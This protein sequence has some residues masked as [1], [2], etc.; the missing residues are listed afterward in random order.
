M[1]T[2][3]LKYRPSSVQGREGT[4]FY[5]IVHHRVVRSVYTGYHIFPEE[6]NASLSIVNVCGTH[7]RQA[8]LRLIRSKVCWELRQMTTVIMEKEHTMV[9]YSADDLISAYSQ[10]PHYQTLFTFIRKQIVIKK[11]VG[12]TGTARTYMNA[13]GSF[14]IFRDGEDIAFDSLNW[15]IIDMYEAWMKNRG[16]KRNSSSCYLRTLRTLYRKAVEQ[17][18]TE[19][20]D[21]FR[22]VFTGFAKTPK[23][24][25]PVSCLKAIKLLDLPLASSLKFARDIFLFSFY[26]R[27]MSFVDIAYLR[28]TDLKN[29]VVIY[30]RKK[31]QQTLTIEWGC[32]MQEIV[33]S[34]AAFTKDSPYLLPIITRF[35]G[36]ERRQYEMME[37]KINRRLKKI[38]EMVNLHIPLTTYVARHTWA[39]TARDIGCPVSVISKGMGHESLKTT[40]IYLSTVD[41]MD[42]DEANRKILGNLMHK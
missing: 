35:D 22:H 15:E 33:D 26:M 29:G 30:N 13:L 40:E 36:T 19:N 1:A 2:L 11:K 28:K 3:K 32:H 7:E 34:Y 27:G 6:W 42:V 25:I 24:A 12:R 18:L 17:N 8:Q 39:S 23:R 16:L 41:S 31:T 9:C 10:L 21:I 37:Q 38:A 20:N 5:Q 14:S 4:L